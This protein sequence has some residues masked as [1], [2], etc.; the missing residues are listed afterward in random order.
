MIARLVQLI[1]KYWDCFYSAGV[2]RPILGIQFCVDTGS[3]QPSCCRQPLYGPFKSR[4]MDKHIQALLN[5]NWIQQWNR[6][7]WGSMIVLASKPHQEKINDIN[8]FVWR[9]CVSYRKLN[10]LT[11]PFKMPIPTCTEAI[12]NFAPYDGCLY[13]IT[14]DAGSGFHQITVADDTK[15]KLAFFG[16]GHMKY[17]WRVMPFGPVNAPTVYITLM[18]RLRSMWTRCASAHSRLKSA[19][20][21]SSQI[22]DDT[23]LWSNSIPD[24]LLYLDIILSVCLDFRIS[25]KLKKCT[26]L[27]PYLEFVGV[28]MSADGQMPAASKYSLIRQWPLPTCQSSLTSFIGLCGFYR[29][30]CPWF[31]VNL[32]PFRSLIKKYNGF[33]IPLMAWS[34]TLRALFNSIKRDLTSDPCLARACS[35]KYFFLKT[36][37]SSAGMGWILMQPDDSSASQAALAALREG[38][39]D[40]C[41]FDLNLNGPRLR[42][43]SFG[44]CKTTKPESKYHSMT[45]EACSGR[46]GIGCNRR[47]SGVVTSAGSLIASLLK[48][49]SIMMVLMCSSVDGVKNCL[50]IISL[51]STAPAA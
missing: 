34:P 11:P 41:E 24:L 37:W 2:S 1:H 49:C 7:A 8:S 19:F 16:P 47:F 5:K 18:L 45:G 23:L 43:T 25:L 10:S 31:E 14:L 42:P 28:N 39:S 29:R 6:G 46:Y 38:D 40:S 48:R 50:V 36:D 20:Y 3:A 26:F 32:S 30:F 15:D 4:I 21:G 51:S 27:D 22:V 33:K 9:L 12:E 13:F 17:T 35:S 44:S